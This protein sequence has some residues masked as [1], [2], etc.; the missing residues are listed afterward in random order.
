MPLPGGLRRVASCQAGMRCTP[1]CEAPQGEVDT[2]VLPVTVQP[3]QSA[4]D[5]HPVVCSQPIQTALPRP[6]LP[7]FTHECP[8]L[9]RPLA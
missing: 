3:V 6:S 1:R 5:A 9:P 7:R 8:V 4:W 2:V